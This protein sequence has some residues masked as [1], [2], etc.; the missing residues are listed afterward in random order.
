M[1]VFWT[2]PGESIYPRPSTRRVSHGARN[3]NQEAGAPG[4]A[5]MVHGTEEVSGSNQGSFMLEASSFDR[6]GAG[7]FGPVITGRGDRTPM[8]DW[9]ERPSRHGTQGDRLRRGQPQSSDSGEDL[10]VIVRDREKGASGGGGALGPD[11]LPGDG[12][13]DSDEEH[14]HPKWGQIMPV[15]PDPAPGDYCS[16]GASPSEQNECRDRCASWHLCV[17]SCSTRWDGRRCVVEP[18]CVPCGL[19]RIRQFGERLFDQ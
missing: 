10:V 1:P 16:G 6:H 9:E 4:L 11:A 14:W 8:S 5:V 2:A 15:E 18:K 7:M 19:E 13:D 3:P 12:V 17:Y